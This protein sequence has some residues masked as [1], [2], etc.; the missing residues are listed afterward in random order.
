MELILET[1]TDN[2]FADLKEL[3]LGRRVPA[4]VI[5]IT[6]RVNQN[7]L[8]PKLSIYDNFIPKTGTVK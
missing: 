3:L 8:N 2:L 4:D 6:T 5:E 7:P 1:K